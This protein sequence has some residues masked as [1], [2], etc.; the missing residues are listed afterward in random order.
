MLL[1]AAAL[2]AGCGSSQ[3]TQSS[4]GA[5]AVTT[6]PPGAAQL[7]GAVADPPRPAA[8]LI[9]RDSLGHRIDIRRYRGRAVLVTF[10]YTHCP[11]V[12]PLIAGNL[13]TALVRLGP[14]ARRVQLVAV[15]TDPIGDTPRTVAAFLAS[16]ELTGRMEYLIGSAAQLSRV[17]RTWGIASQ[18]DP[19]NPELVAHS[20]LIYGISG[21]GDVTTLYPS[22]FTPDQIV[23]DVPILASR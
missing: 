6:P 11:D 15:S 2:I 14:A 17:W 21:S 18:R 13:H 23:H 8:P 1:A 3:S 22:N 7:A 5:A 12:C 10:L 20:A 4:A 19:H 16:H 9:L